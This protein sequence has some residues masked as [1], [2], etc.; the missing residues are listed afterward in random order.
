MWAAHTARIR[1]NARLAVMQFNDDL[2]IRQALDQRPRP[3]KKFSVGDEVVVWRGGT[4]KG[5]PGKQR[6]AQ[7]RGSRHHLGGSPL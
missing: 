5:A 1:S 2:A 7:W 3:L 4:G 6:R